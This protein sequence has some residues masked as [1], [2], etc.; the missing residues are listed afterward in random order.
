MLIF[1]TFEDDLTVKQLFSTAYLFKRCY[2]TRNY[3]KLPTDKFIVFN[4]SA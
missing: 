3:C 1:V 2:A 4:F